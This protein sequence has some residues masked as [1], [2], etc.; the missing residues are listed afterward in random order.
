MM[1]KIDT[2]QLKHLSSS[3]D[4]SI[5]GFIYIQFIQFYIFLDVAQCAVS[6][7]NNEIGKIQKSRRTDTIKRHE[8]PVRKVQV[9]AKMGRQSKL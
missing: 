4:D 8:S 6:T 1:L 9:R 3:S 5:N 2:R 7:R